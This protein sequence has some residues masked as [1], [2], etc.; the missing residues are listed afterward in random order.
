MAMRKGRCRNFG[1]CDNADKHT[2]L[3]VPE[4][5]DFNCPTC[6]RQLEKIEPGTGGGGM[7][8]LV[9]IVIVLAV[10]AAGYLAYKRFSSSDGGGGTSFKLTPGSK[11]KEG[12][13]RCRVNIWVGCAGGLAANGG[14]DTQPGSE[15]DKQGIKVSFKIIDDW[16]EGTAALASN[17][18]DVMLTTTDVW[19]K[20]YATLKDKGFSGRAFLMVDWSRGADGVIGR[21]GIR[22]VEDLAGKSIAFAPYTPSHFLLW[23]GLENSGLSRG[24]RDTIMNQAIHTKDGIEPATLFAQGKVDAAVAWDPDM[25]D[26]VSKRAGAVKI[27]DT[28]IASKLIADILVVSD[29]FLRAHPDTVTKFA[30]GWLKGVDYVKN[31]PSR[32][33]NLIGGIKDFNMPADLA[34]TM[35]GGVMLSNYSDNLAFFGKVGER[36]DYANIFGMAQDMYRE[37]LQIKQLTPDIEAT[38]TR[39]V[40]LALQ[41]QFPVAPVPTPTYNSNATRTQPEISEMHKTINF[42]VDSATISMDSK[43]QVDDIGGFMQAYENTVVEIVGNTDSSGDRNHNILLSKRRADAV[44]D[45]LIANYH[46]PAAR[47]VTVGAGPDHPVADNSTPEG[48]EKNRR[49]D[50]RAYPNK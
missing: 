47:I 11:G 10:V 24:Q 32:A 49:S 2:V 23:Y 28:R 25:S 37:L 29:D 13:V 18:V 3:D 20:D 19:A 43:S 12:E 17:N 22:K 16:T 27:Y 36:T 5:G 4:T 44:K 39:Q 35:L 7:K 8:P 41:N 46:F 48:R 9:L 14:L 15:F 42:D 6:G 21:D 38:M 50:I 26:A 40:L 33:Y 1:N 34:K 45:Y 30:A 31:D